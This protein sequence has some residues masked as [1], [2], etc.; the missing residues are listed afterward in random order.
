MGKISEEDVSIVMK[1]FEKLDID[2]SG[3]LSAVDITLA[4][5]FQ[6]IG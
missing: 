5:S 1:E 2:Q 3:T 4:Q 6:A